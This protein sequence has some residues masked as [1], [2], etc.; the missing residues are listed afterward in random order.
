MSK[1]NIQEQRVLGTKAVE[2]D[3][4]GAYEIRTSQMTLTMFLGVV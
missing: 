1:G 4:N 2:P 3:S